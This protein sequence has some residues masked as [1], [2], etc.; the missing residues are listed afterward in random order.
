MENKI[1]NLEIK[2]NLAKVTKDIKKLADSFEDTSEEI[3]GIQKSSKNAGDGVQSLTAG[4]KFLGL[5]IK[6]V[7]ISLILEAF[8]LFKEVLGQNQKV[9]DLFSTAIG[10]LSIAFNDLIGF[11]V[12]NFPAVVKIFKDVFQNPT[13]YLKQ[14]GDLV[15]ENLIERFN[16]FLD[17]IG[18]LSDALKKVFEGDFVGA[19]DSVKKAGKESVDILTGV[20]NSFDKGKKIIS[21]ASSAIADYAVKT[22]KASEANVNLQNTALI[23]AA[24]QAK[25]VEQYDLQAEQLRKI[26]D[27]DLLSISD[28]IIAN[29]KLKKVLENQKIAM[30]AQ[31]DLQVDAAAATLAM[32]DKIENQ[33]ALINAQANAVGVLAQVEG[34]TSEQEANRVALKKELVEL[35]QSQIDSNTELGTQQKKFNETLENDDLKRLELQRTNLERELITEA[36]GIK[37]KLELYALGTQA[38]AD[39]ETT[40]AAKKQEIDNALTTNEKEQSAKRKEIGDLELQSKQNQLDGISSALSQAAAIAGE[41]TSAGKALAVASTAISTYST[42]QKAYESAF[43]PVPTVASPALGAAFASVA[44]AGGLMNIKKILS[45][46]TPKSVAAP[47]LGGGGV[48]AAPIAPAFNVIGANPTNQLAQ[49]I[50]AQNNIPIKA[51]VVSSDV[52]TAQA[53]DRNI[54]KSATLG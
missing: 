53:L 19:L 35:T 5:A 7:G 25:L 31:A 51:F 22:F 29:D 30:K 42:A 15:Q 46:K 48:P 45:V 26:R 50:G 13:T 21:D 38:R 18:F 41:S 14:F 16:S 36:D 6:A 23:A 49:T 28:R 10:A 52:S 27:N 17:T 44:V 40:Y 54:I 1:V 11:V 9:V 3:K 8:N 34:L 37:R 32:N 2:D 24:Q 43:L 12:N 20:N 33:V 47:S 39:A 4:F